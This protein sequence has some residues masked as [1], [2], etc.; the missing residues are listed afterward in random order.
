MSREKIV[1]A[2]FLKKISSLGLKHLSGRR[3]ILL[4]RNGAL[5][6][7]YDSLWGRKASPVKKLHSLMGI[8]SRGVFMRN[9][10]GLLI[11]ANL[12]LA[13]AA[14]APLSTTYWP[15]TFWHS[16]MTKWSLQK[17]AYDQSYQHSLKALETDPLSP[18]LQINLGN[19]LEGMGSLTKA[20]EAYATSEKLTSDLAVHFQ[21]RFNQAQALAKEKKIDEALA[22]YQKALEIDPTSQ[23]VKTN[24]ELLMSASGGKG[25]KGDK[26]QEQKDDQQKGDGKDEQ[27]SKNPQF[28]ENPKSEGKKQPQ[29]LSPGD[30]KKILEELKQQE[31]K[32]RG[33]YYKQSNNEKKQKGN[34]GKR[35]KD[36]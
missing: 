26:D 20:R 33:D 22:M 18:E 30:I 35:E 5:I 32:I 7:K 11:F 15:Q 6:P 34:S 9:C 13:Q 16:L 17:E 2:L 23:I 4:V 12:S 10:L 8:A 3:H 19:A 29:D 24:I 28:A 21:A 31:Q 1:N 14:A 25:G 36:W 27:Q